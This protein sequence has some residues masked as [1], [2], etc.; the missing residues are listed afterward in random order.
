MS[1]RIAAIFTTYQPEADFRTRIDAIVRRCI[2]TIVMD[3]T[4]GGYAFPDVRGLT[5]RQDGVNK[6]LGRALNLGIEEARRLGCNAVVL[7]DQDSTP[8]ARFV[9]AL[10]QAHERLGAKEVC[11]GPRLLDDATLADAAALTPVGA[12]WAPA[13]VTCLPTSGMFFTLHDV[14]VADTFPEDFFLDFVDF[15]WCWR[16]RA[17][18]WRLYR[19]DHLPMFHRLGLAQRQFLGLTYHVPAPYRHYFQF[20]DTLRLLARSYVPMYFK[21]RLALIL[22]PKFIAY[23]IVLDHGLERIRWM[24]RGIVDAWHGV[25]GI[26]AASTTLNR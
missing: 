25:G 14:G 9:D 1:H 3:N 18:G 20:R 23:P 5:V 6:G 24:L 17:K 11:V 2:V 15:D 4:P 7:F 21:F 12:S 13:E 8:D 22:V 26:G 16:M 10:V 19:L